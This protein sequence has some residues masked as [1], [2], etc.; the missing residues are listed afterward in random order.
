[1]FQVLTN[2]VYF[3]RRRFGE[4]SERLYDIQH[5]PKET[6]NLVESNDHADELREQLAE[7]RTKLEDVKYTGETR[8]KQD[9]LD[10]QTEEQLREMGYI[11]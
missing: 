8:D 9:G 6:E 2:P 4:T 7:W 3:L 11:E 1:M 10:E 5:D